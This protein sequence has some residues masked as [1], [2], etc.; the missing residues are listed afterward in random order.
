MPPTRCIVLILSVLFPGG[1]CLSGDRLQVGGVYPHLTMQNLESECG[2][3]A[4]VPWNDGLYVVTYAPHRPAGSTDKLYRVDAGLNQTIHPKSVGG[5]PANRM[6]HRE[7]DQLLIGPYVI[8]R[9]DNVRVLS[10]ERMFGRLTG[11]AR[12]LTQPATSVYYATMEEGLYE[13]DLSDLSV[14]SLIR[15][16][17]ARNGPGVVTDLPGYHGKGLY[18]GQGRVIYTNNGTADPRRLIDPTIPSGALAQWTG[19]GDWQLIRRNQFTEVTGPGGLHGNDD[20][21]NP[22]W[23][24]GWDARSILLGMMAEGRWSYFR[25][26]KASHSYDG[27]HGWNTEWPRIRDIG[28]E[29]WLATMHGTFWQFPATFGPGRTAGIRA[30]SNYLKVIGDFCRWND[31]VVLGCDDSALSE[32]AN[33]RPLKAQG[34]ATGQSH[35]NLWFVDPQRLGRIGPVIGR[36]S[37]YLRD[38]VEAGSVSDPFLIDGYE[39]R[40]IALSHRGDAAATIQLQID[41]DGDQQFQSYKTITLPP[42]GSVIESLPTDLDGVWM[43][44][45]VRDRC[46]SLTIH[47]QQHHRDRRSNDPDEKFE[48]LASSDDDVDNRV[49]LRSLDAQTLGL[50]SQR[51][52]QEVRLMTMDQSLSLTPAVADDSTLDLTDLRQPAGVVEV[53]DH[54][55]LVVEGAERYRLPRHPDAALDRR[56]TA[57]S[58][59]LGPPRIC[60]EIATERDLLHVDQTFYE[61]PAINASG[62]AKVRPVATHGYQIFDFCSHNGLLFLS[63]VRPEASSPRIVASPDRRAAVWVGVI[64]ELWQMGKV[65]G[66]GGPWYRSDVQPSVPSD[67]YLMTGYDQKH[68]A[69]TSDVPTTVSMEL[70]V[71]GTGL[72]V[73]YKSYQVAAD[74]PAQE[75]LPESL[76]AY[77]CRFVTSQLARV[78]TT[79]TYR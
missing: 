12:H 62:M 73:P 35:S 1:I 60:R 29:S 8:D 70:D 23:T 20:V 50:W 2:T 40:Q 27:A 14:K 65:R 49:L 78:T 72:W 56:A 69:I 45:V 33:K 18:S 6:I 68:L 13:V 55:V 26:P 76:A 46:E 71:D 51:D 77:W 61:L 37:I 9:Q 11:N 41:A 58:S 52:A 24:L 32:F 48:G 39:L 7:T 17:A 43:R 42:A 25:L 79:L 66:V 5:T 22:I 53:T 16:T 67:R 64:D 30:R 4:V 3:G 75:T 19:S 44:A 57:P 59:V 21:D 15:D 28:E 54:S 38:D 10:P 36:G 63:G 47:F 31:H 34:L 74:H